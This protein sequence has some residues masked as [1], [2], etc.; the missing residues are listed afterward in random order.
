MLNLAALGG[1]VRLVLVAI[2]FVFDMMLI[3]F[4]S[5]AEP[6]GLATAPRRLLCATIGRAARLA[7]RGLIA[8]LLV[9]HVGGGGGPPVTEAAFTHAE[10][11]TF[12]PLTAIVVAAPMIDNCVA[13]SV[14]VVLTVTPRVTITGHYLT[15]G[16][17]RSPWRA[18]TS[19]CGSAPEPA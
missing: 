3:R 14:L 19:R 13:Q 6:S 5:G 16:H 7:R 8:V 17:R 9:A 15:A 12:V 4:T 11:A 18:R 10:H 1:L 2:A